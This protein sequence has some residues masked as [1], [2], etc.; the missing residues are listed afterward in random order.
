MLYLFINSNT[1]QTFKN[2]IIITLSNGYAYEYC[3]IIPAQV[4]RKEKRMVLNMNS[5][6]LKYIL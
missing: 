5:I 1:R 6:H 2:R 3:L 4:S